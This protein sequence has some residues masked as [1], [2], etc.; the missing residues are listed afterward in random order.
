MRRA[1]ERFTDILVDF[2]TGNGMRIIEEALLNTV[3]L[4]Y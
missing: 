2:L 1:C 3:Q 4:L